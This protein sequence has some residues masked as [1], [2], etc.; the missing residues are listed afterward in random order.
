MATGEVGLFEVNEEAWDE[1][2]PKLVGRASPIDSL[3]T[4]IRTGG[5][6]NKA[7]GLVT[8]DDLQSA[9]AQM[10]SLK[11]RLGGPEASGFTFQVR[12]NGAK[13]LVTASFNAGVVTEA[14]KAQHVKDTEVRLQK[15]RE[16]NEKAKAKKAAEGAKS[17]QSA[18]NG[19]AAEPAP[20]PA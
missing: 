3:L 6:T 2:K 14:G 11:T 7:Y 16:A 19:K 18:T 10:N 17:K 15:A 4:Q 8:Y 20:V 12:T 1:V 13:Y 9:R 5:E